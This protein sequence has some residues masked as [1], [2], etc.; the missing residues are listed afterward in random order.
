MT[1][2]MKII[3][4][5][6]L[7]LLLIFYLFS[8]D[9]YHGHSKRRLISIP[10]IGMGVVVLAYFII[11][12]VL[13]YVTGI[14]FFS[15]DLKDVLIAGFFGAGMIEEWCK[16]IGVMVLLYAVEKTERQYDVLLFTL[17]I[18]ALFAGLEN[19]IIPRYFKPN[20]LILRMFTAV[21]AHVIFS[22]IMSL[23]LW[24][25]MTGKTFI[26]KLSLMFTALV[27]PA[28]VHAG[29]NY[30]IFFIENTE[31][32]SNG[33]KLGIFTLIFIFL[34]VFILFIRNNIIALNRSVIFNEIGDNPFE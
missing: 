4:A 33:F 1:L 20:T 14:D 7:P 23:L 19:M 12:R 26:R 8:M 34:A 29:F 3:L 27:I 25:M 30:F 18:G 31:V 24:K 2:I 11:N 32:I 6:G 16:L 28:I 9:I 22:Y 10:L 17:S 15:S 13:P 21:P 5:I